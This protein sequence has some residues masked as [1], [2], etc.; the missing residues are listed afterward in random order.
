MQFYQQTSPCR[1]WFLPTVWTFQSRRSSRLHYRCWSIHC[2]PEA[3]TFNPLWHVSP[4]QSF[5]FYHYFRKGCDYL[6]YVSA[7]LN[8]SVDYLIVVKVFEP[9]E[10]LFG[11]ED[12]SGFVVFQRTPFGAQER[13]QT[14][15][16]QNW[17]RI[18]WDCSFLRKESLVLS[19]YHWK[20]QFFLF[21]LSF[22]TVSL[23][24]SREIK[25]G[26]GL[27]LRTHIWYVSCLSDQS[28][29]R[30]RRFV[31]DEQSLSSEPAT[32][33]NKLPVDVT[34]SRSYTIMYKRDADF[35]YP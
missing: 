27:G 18:I 33:W 29:Y 34:Q 1:G 3:Q 6:P 15:Y 17:N 2:H 24:T 21:A 26:Y 4:K 16:K 12:D 10:D 13:W 14:A 35:L 25:P 23:T 22:S 9:L 19:V 32:S 20:T 30:Q 7:H 11:V 5:F 8:V 31:S 28:G